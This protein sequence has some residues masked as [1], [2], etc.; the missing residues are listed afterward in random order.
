MRIPFN[1]GLQLPPI[2]GASTSSSL[3]PGPAGKRITLQRNRSKSVINKAVDSPENLS[4]PSPERPRFREVPIDGDGRCLFRA[5]AQANHIAAAMDPKQTRK[6]MLLGPDEERVQADS[7]RHKVCDL[8]L[9]RRA[10]V[11]PFIEF[12]GGGEA[13][14]LGDCAGSYE[15]YVNRMRLVSTWG[16]EPELAMSAEVLGR[17]VLV[18][19]RKS[20][21][22]YVEI[23]TYSPTEKIPNPK[24]TTKLNL[25]FHSFG[26]Y[27]LLVPTSYSDIIVRL[28]PRSRL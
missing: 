2:A 5:L 21:A 15:E 14:M 17:E 28:P 13:S 12:G 11:E 22:G 25:L 16:G 19:A 7:L 3:F 23:S 4:G 6:T 9:E 1:R 20:R 26:H 27:D 18:F 24:N 8:L 10:D